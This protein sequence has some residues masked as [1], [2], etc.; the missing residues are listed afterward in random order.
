VV[1]VRT[2]TDAGKACVQFRGCT[3]FGGVH[4]EKYKPARFWG[5]FLL[6]DNDEDTVPHAGTNLAMM[7]PGSGRFS[8]RTYVNLANNSLYTIE[9]QHLELMSGHKQPL[10]F[11]AAACRIIEAGKP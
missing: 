10:R 3:S 8:K 11:S 6:A 7:R 1:I 4:V 2:T 5:Q 9:Y